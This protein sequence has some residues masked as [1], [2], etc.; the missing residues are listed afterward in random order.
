MPRG[1]GEKRKERKNLAAE[2]EKGGGREI[3]KGGKETGFFLRGKKRKGGDRA[4][5][6]LSFGKE[7]KGKRKVRGSP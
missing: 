2:A 7:K 1:G 6:C 5:G 3:K 4:G